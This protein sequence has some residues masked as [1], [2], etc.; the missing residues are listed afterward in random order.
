MIDHPALTVEPSCHASLS[1]APT[2]GVAQAESQQ[3]DVLLSQQ[4]QSPSSFNLSMPQWM[5]AESLWVGGLAIAAWGLM[6][7][8][9]LTGHPHLTHLFMHGGTMHVD[10]S[11]SMVANDS[12]AE[13]HTMPDMHAMPDMHTTMGHMEGTEQHGMAQALSSS[14]LGKFG[15]F[16]IAWQVMIIAMMFPTIIP[17]LRCFAIASRNQPRHRL[18]VATVVFAYMAVW[19]GFGSLVFGVNLL[20]NWCMSLSPWLESHGWMLVGG[21]LL[22]TGVFQFSSLKALCMEQCQAPL[23]AVTQRY[24]RGLKAAWD[25]GISQ[26]ISCV[27]CCWALMVVMVAAQLCSLPWMLGLT[28]IMLLEKNGR[29]GAELI[30][31]VGVGFMGLGAYVFWQHHLPTFLT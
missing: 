17:V 20:L 22:I 14:I 7:V 31:F 24:R 30:S 21:A 9:T 29:L 26:G 19:S 10:P 16:A 2:V 5:R 25:L 27:G 23:L 13:M 18:A 15:Y 28:G 6:L 8:P 1:Y 12:M 3:V 11:H 4:S